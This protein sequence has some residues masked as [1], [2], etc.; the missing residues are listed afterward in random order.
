M[1]D[2][3]N[4]TEYVTFA[5]AGQL[6]GLPIG[7]VQDVFKPATI[8]RVPLAAPEIAGVLN[9][10][11]RIVTAIHLY[12]RLGLENR[13]RAAMPMA[14]GIESGSESFGLLVDSVGEVLKLADADREP[15]P[16]NLDRNLARVSSGVFRL[17][18]QLLVVL[19]IDRLLD[20]GTEAAAA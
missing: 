16:I 17:D 10:R 4:L 18:G 1:N 15:N 7:R 13:N 19:D 2:N 11:G 14:I 8:T 3:L 12:A 9:L 6:F 5:T 20:L